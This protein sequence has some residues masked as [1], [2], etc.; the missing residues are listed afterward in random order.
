M[1]WVF[2][3]SSAA[4]N[5]PAMQET[6]RRCVL[7]PWVGK[8]TCKQGKQQSRK[9]H[10]ESIAY[11]LTP[12]PQVN[13]KCIKIKHKAWN[14]K[15]P[16]RKYWGKHFNIG[17]DKEFFNWPQNKGN[18]SKNKQVNYI[19]LKILHSKGSNQ[20]NEKATYLWSRGKYLQSMYLLR[21]S[22]AKCIRNSVKSRAKEKF[23]IN[24]MIHGGLPWW[25]SG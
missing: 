16:R 17:F 15:T 23:S 4:K 20:Q 5:S 11:Y 10:E 12:Y 13:S 6:C 3:G 21:G 2:P 22:Y 7:G 25:S 19:K 9:H 1:Q 14:C 8:T 18:E 24:K